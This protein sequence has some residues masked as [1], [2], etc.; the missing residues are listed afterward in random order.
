[1]DN[2]L[3]NVNQSWVWEYFFSHLGWV[4]WLLLVFLLMGIVMGLSHGMSQELPR[5]LEILICLYVTFEYSSFFADWLARETPWPEAYARVFV[6]ALLGFLSWLS[7]RLLFAIMGKLIHLEVATP[8]QIVGGAVVGLVRYFIFFCFIS[9]F[10]ILF[11][12]DWIHRSYQVQSWSGKTLAQVGP[13]IHGSIKG[14][15]FSRQGAA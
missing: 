8:L 1:M 2:F 13:K 5:L 4:D 15:V 11:P 14:L 7:L 12:L 10:L 3:G 9:S 6:F